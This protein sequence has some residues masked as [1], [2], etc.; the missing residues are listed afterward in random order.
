MTVESQLSDVGGWENSNSAIQ[1]AL[2][3]AVRLLRVHCYQ[4]T[5]QFTAAL[6]QLLHRKKRKRKPKRCGGHKW[7]KANS[8]VHN[9]NIT[10]HQAS[11]ITEIGM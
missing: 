3:P 10:L 6:P 11:L 7:P 1:L 5:C 2:P 8:I 9:N 4:I